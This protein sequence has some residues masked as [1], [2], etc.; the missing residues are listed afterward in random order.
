MIANI[1]FTRRSRDGVG[2]QPRRTSAELIAYARFVR[3][4]SPEQQATRNQ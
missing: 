1:V 4:S 3:R 2:R